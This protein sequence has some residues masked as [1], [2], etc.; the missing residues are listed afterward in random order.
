MTLA[1]S[2]SLLDRERGFIPSEVRILVRGGIAVIGISSRLSADD[3]VQDGPDLVAGALPDLV[4][5]LAFAED[6]LAGGGVLSG[7]G[8]D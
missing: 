5:G 2:S 7:G 8:A 6:L 3:S 4:A 1:M